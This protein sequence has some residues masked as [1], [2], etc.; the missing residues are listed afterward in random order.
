[1]SVGDKTSPPRGLLGSLFR[2]IEGPFPLLQL[3][4]REHLIRHK[5]HRVNLLPLSKVCN[6]VWV[7][8]QV[9]CYSNLS[10]TAKA[11][12]WR[13][14]HVNVFTSWQS[15]TTFSTFADEMSVVE[16]RVRNEVVPVDLGKVH[17]FFYILPFLWK[18]FFSFQQKYVK[19]CQ[20]WE[21]FS[22][23]WDI[24][25]LWSHSGFWSSQTY[26]FGVYQEYIIDV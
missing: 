21:W 9:L 23:V 22:K 4:K 17:L 25:G 7:I 18:I 15:L 14:V 6:W 11:I 10:N 26:P 24:F 1:M 20:G 8:C 3:Q 19:N 13:C 16:L 5:W 2:T 12:V